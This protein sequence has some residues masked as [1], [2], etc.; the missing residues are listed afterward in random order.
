MYI[1]DFDRNG[2]AEQI[3]TRYEADEAYPLALRHDL[4][5]QMPSLRKKYLKY[6]DYR[7]QSIE[8]VF[9]PAQLEKAIRLEVTETRSMVFLNT[10]DTAFT[11]VALPVE[12]QLAPLFGLLLRDL[13]GDHKPD[14]LAGGNFYRAK[15]E[16]GIYD[17]SYGLFLKG[18]GAGNF[19]SIPSLQS[20]FMVKGEIRDLVLIHIGGSSC[21]L[22]AKNNAPWEGFDLN[23]QE[24]AE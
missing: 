10:A 8:E 22:V 6:E 2:S 13:D 15:P 12:A 3:I 4:I 7:E 14:L 18:D 5:K 19:R 16:V 17:A 9:T 11:A 21:V 1:N 23:F 20:G 24:I